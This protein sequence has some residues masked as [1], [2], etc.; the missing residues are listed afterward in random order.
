MALK[1]AYQSPLDHQDLVGSQKA[2]ILGSSLGTNAEAWTPA[3]K[4]IGDDIKPLVYDLPGHGNS[5][6]NPEWSIS[7]VADAVVALADELELRAFSFAGVSISGQVGI[8]LAI[9]YP[10][11]LHALVAICTSPKISDRQFWDERIENVSQFG[12]D[13]VV[14]ETQRSWFSEKFQERKPEVVS[15]SLQQLRQI[16]RSSYLAACRAIDAYDAWPLLPKLEVPTLLI[17]GEQDDVVSFDSLE[18]ACALIPDCGLIQ[19]GGVKHQAHL[20]A[21]E[22]IMKH[23]SFYARKFR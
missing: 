18:R 11:R 17:H 22:V 10:D 21:P 8:D 13:E 5:A 12:L 9:R 14:E 2:L 19:I 20:E 23:I 1:L 4:F 6:P 16:D 15:A 7:E 3:L